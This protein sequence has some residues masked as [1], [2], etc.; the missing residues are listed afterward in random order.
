MCQC[1]A[2]SRGQSLV[3]PGYQGCKAGLPPLA[4]Q[5]FKRAKRKHAEA[6]G[7]TL[8]DLFVLGTTGTPKHGTSKALSAAHDKKRQERLATHTL[9]QV[10][11]VERRQAGQRGTA[12][13]C[14]VCFSKLGK[15]TQA[16]ELLTCQERLE[17]L[18]TNGFSMS[19]KRAWS[20]HLQEPEPLHAANFLKAVNRSK[21]FQDEFFKVGRDT[22][23]SKRWRS[24]KPKTTKPKPHTPCCAG[25]K[26]QRKKALEASRALRTPKTSAATSSS[27]R[28]R[29]AATKPKA[30]A[31]PKKR[32]SCS[33]SGLSPCL[34][35]LVT[36]ALGALASTARVHLV[37]GEL[38]TKSWLRS[39]RTSFFSK[40]LLS[41][42]LRS[43]ALP[44]CVALKGVT[45]RT[46]SPLLVKRLAAS[47][48]ACEQGPSPAT[49]CLQGARQRA[50]CRSL[51][52]WLAL[53]EHVCPS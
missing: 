12:W 49:R 51:C 40:K 28:P 2:S 15:T 13:Y 30:K 14:S 4:S 29:A 34:V 47:L 53:A 20:K 50:D 21:E 43:R 48:Y 24:K 38:L 25:L 41:R 18:Q 33:S 9:V 39:N 5:P 36:L 10:D 1:T 31:K 35:R 42:P 17:R 23:S 3:L 11:T 32:R 45:P 8:R 6:H 52:D 26:L 27:A 37:R 46:F 16:H 22:Y 44:S 7:L 19:K